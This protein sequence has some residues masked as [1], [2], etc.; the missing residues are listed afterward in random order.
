MSKDD[1]ASEFSL[2]VSRALQLLSTFNASRVELGLTELSQELG[3][4]KTATSRL[5]HALQMHQYIEQ[6]PQTR[7]YRIGAEAFRVGSLFAPGQRIE[8]HAADLMR[9]LVA[10]TGFTSY[11]SL[12]KQDAMVLTFSVEGPGP[13]RYSIP[14]GTR[15]QVHAS[16]TGKAALAT[17]SDSEV[18]A[19][20]ART[21]LK[22]WTPS[23]VRSPE[24]LKADLAGIRERGY[25][26]NWEELTLGVGSVAAP[27]YKRD[28]SLLAV[29]SIGFATSQVAREDMPQLGER[30]IRTANEISRRV[31]SD[32]EKNS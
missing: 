18:D 13:V 11:I 30:L 5:L 15:L 16:A 6:N 31:L 1:S 14:I 24:T 22:A 3:I 29:I 28:K 23:T 4:S 19:I 26:L 20:L 27:I 8:E 21:G 32:A 12:L 9:A 2:T 7:K 25:S 10:K 17:L